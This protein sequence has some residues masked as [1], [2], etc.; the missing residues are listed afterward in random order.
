MNCK[1]VRKYLFAFA[2]GQ[3]GVQANCEVLDHLKMCPACSKIVNEH[4]A[5]RSKLRFSAEQIKVPPLLEGR[6]RKAI[7]LGRPIRFDETEH[8]WG[9]RNRVLRVAALAACITLIVTGA[10][11]IGPWGTSTSNPFGNTIN[12]EKQLAQNTALNV[13]KLHFSCT[14]KCE[15]PGHHHDNLPNNREKVAGA[16]RRHY[17]GQLLAIA[18]DLSGYGFEFE[19]ANFCCPAGCKDEVGAHAMY[20]DYSNGN[21]LSLF[22][23]LH[24]D[25]IDV[26]DKPTPDRENPFIHSVSQCDDTWILAWHENDMTYI[27]CGLSAPETLLNMVN[28]MQVAVKTDVDLHDGKLA[29]LS[30]R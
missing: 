17:D 23:V 20:V 15:G 14:R 10:W 13:R 5:V 7:Q 3:I 29:G 12:S 21:R 27:C 6:V 11:Y 9:I 16:I 30:R 4:Q 19:S 24:W 26:P 22:S 28:D 25:A 2:D 8:S 18:P 1:T